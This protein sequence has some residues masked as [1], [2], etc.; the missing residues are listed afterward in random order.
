MAQNDFL[1]MWPSQFLHSICTYLPSVFGTL[2]RHAED[3]I[4]PIKI[5]MEHLYLLKIQNI[6]YL[7]FIMASGTCIIKLNT[8]I[9]E[10]SL[11]Y[12]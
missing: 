4:F 10:F 3:H 8:S 6:G 1:C 7:D 2:C 9:R 12:L 11:T 5:Y